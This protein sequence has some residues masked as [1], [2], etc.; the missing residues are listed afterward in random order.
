MWVSLGKYGQG[1]ATVVRSGW[2]RLIGRG[3]VTWIVS[4]YGCRSRGRDGWVWASLDRYGQ[5]WVKVGKSGWVRLM[6]R[7]LVVGSWYACR[8]MGGCGWAWVGAP[9]SNT[10]SNFTSCLCI[11]SPSCSVLIYFKYSMYSLIHTQIV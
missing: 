4:G 6:G 3:W 2:D 7:G 10:H 1:W 9:F 5:G 11:Y 8:S